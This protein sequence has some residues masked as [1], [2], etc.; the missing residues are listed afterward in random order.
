M[1]GVAMDIRTLAIVLVAA[2]A[3]GGHAQVADHLKCYSGKDPAVTAL[4]T[5]DLD[6]LVP[7]PGCQVKVPAKLVCVPTPKTNVQPTPPNPTV[8]GSAATMMVCYKVKCVKAA[9]PPVAVADQFGARVLAAKT[10]KLLCAPVPVPPTPTTT[11]TTTVGSTSTSTTTPSS[12]T[13]TLVPVVCCQGF[14]GASVQ[15]CGMTTVA[16][17]SSYGTVT[18]G[19]CRSDG[20]C[21]AAAA[22]GNCCDVANGAGLECFVEKLAGATELACALWAQGQGTFFASAN[23]TAAGCVP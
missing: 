3:T 2:V 8:V 21:G 20:T 9:L 13:T 17:C 10:A 6:G 12:T 4:Y 11:S 15:G 22:A 5:A 1:P 14:F 7:E 18:S 16:A 19:V 23:C